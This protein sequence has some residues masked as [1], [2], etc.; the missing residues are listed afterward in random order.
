MNKFKVT[1]AVVGLGV[2]AGM[3][4]FYRRAEGKEIP[5]YRTAPVVRASLKSTVSATGAL[6]ACEWRANA[7][8]SRFR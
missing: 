7:W 2:V 3:A 4:W 1:A 8:D 5:A 6:S